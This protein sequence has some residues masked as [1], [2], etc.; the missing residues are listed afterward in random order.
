MKKLV[1]L[2]RGESTWNRENRF[3]EGC[4]GCGRTDEEDIKMEVKRCQA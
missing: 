2:R 1:L 4:S 3:K